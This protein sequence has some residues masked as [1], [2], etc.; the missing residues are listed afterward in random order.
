MAPDCICFYLIISFPIEFCFLNHLL[1]FNM[2]ILISLF[3]QKSTLIF[4]FNDYHISW[5]SQ[6]ISLF[7]LF[8]ELFQNR[9]KIISLSF[10]GE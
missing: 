5:N 10:F 9:F 8:I 3:S 6:Y 2:F 7:Q 1:A 4:L